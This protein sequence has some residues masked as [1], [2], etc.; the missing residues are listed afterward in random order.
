[1]T[2]PPSASTAEP[3]PPRSTAA[4]LPRVPGARALW[5]LVALLVALR[6]AAAL[7][8][9]PTHVDEGGW[10]L[11]VREWA[12]AGVVSPDLHKAPLYHVVLGLVF[13]VATPTLLTAR[14]LSVLLGA[15]SLAL[16]WRAVRRLDPDPRVAW[17]SVLLW[18]ACFPAI[19]L[20]SRALI[21]PLQLAWL[22][23]LLA[24]L[25]AT[26]ARAGL[27][28]AVASAGLLLTKA[29]ALVVLPA[30]ALAPWLDV[31]PAVRAGRGAKLA[32]LC[33]GTAVAAATYGALYLSDPAT[34]LRGWVETLARPDVASGEGA[35]RLGRLAVDLRTIE[36]GLDFLAS[37]APFLLALGTVGAL[38]A[39]AR[40]EL[41]PFAFALLLAFPFVLLQ[42]DQPPQYFAM[43]YPLFAVLAA[44]WLAEALRAEPT[45]GSRLLRWPV[46]AVALLVTEGLART[47]A[48]ALLLRAPERPAVAW[49]RANVAPGER[50]LAAPY[51]V[52]QLPTEGRSIFAVDSAGG[53]PSP[54]TLAAEQVT[55][56][57]FD[58]LEWGHYARRGGLD[59]AAVE[60]HFAAC[61]A[62]VWADGAV[63]VLRVK[64]DAPPPA[65]R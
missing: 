35:I 60:A 59:S 1:M 37:Q 57:A 11:S 3:A 56:I 52:M 33:V 63:R 25:T 7:L 62:P 48:A 24:A 29:N 36:H 49:L 9:L 28:V 13:R 41:L 4:A 14:L 58:T 15:L 19:D 53:V 21:E 44:A 47:A 46:L 50:V 54:R 40:R 16:L 5:A 51:I 22:C 65:G 17:W 42:A 31:A 27:A 20:G 34:F 30:M 39:V 43:L 38:R 8:S 64:P 26:G 45:A 6:A 2:I 55:W 10:P 23:A 18:G 32:G 61:C 12:T